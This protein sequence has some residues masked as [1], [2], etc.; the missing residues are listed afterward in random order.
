[1]TTNN[2]EDSAQNGWSLADTHLRGTDTIN[3]SLMLDIRGAPSPP[4]NFAAEVVAPMRVRLTWDRNIL[5]LKDLDLEDPPGYRIEWSADGDAPWTS[6]VNITNQHV[7]D[8]DIWCG[9]LSPAVQRRYHPA[10]DHAVLPD[11]DGRRGRGCRFLVHRGQR[12][13]ARLGGFR[14][15]THR[16]WC[17]GVATRRAQRPE[18]VPNPLGERGVPVQGQRGCVEAPGDRD[19]LRAARRSRTLCWT[20]TL[21]SHRGSRRRAR[22]STRSRSRMAGVSATPGTGDWRR[23]SSSSRSCRCARSRRQR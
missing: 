8:S 1:M 9:V 13:H 10:G 7:T 3:S 12:H 14:R 20:R 19:R 11:P 21:V 6:L 16:I 17:G 18:G 2:G 22:A 23:D 4:T 15:R 5:P